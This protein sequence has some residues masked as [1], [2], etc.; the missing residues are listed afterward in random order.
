M[1]ADANT[2]RSMPDIASEAHAAVAGTLDWV[3][4]DEIDVPVR[5]TGAD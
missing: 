2:L 4:M 5:L 3:G 1:H